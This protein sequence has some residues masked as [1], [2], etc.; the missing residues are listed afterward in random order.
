[1]LEEAEGGRSGGEPQGLIRDPAENACVRLPIINHDYWANGYS[2][3]QMQK[4]NPRLAGLFQP[5]D[6]IF[7]SGQPAEIRQA[8]RRAMG[9]AVESI[10]ARRSP[11]VGRGRQP[12][13]PPPGDGSRERAAASRAKR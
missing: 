8:Y 2:I 10:A 9:L 4:E 12:R 6:F 7:Q 13:P 5:N 11:R 3:E 1:M